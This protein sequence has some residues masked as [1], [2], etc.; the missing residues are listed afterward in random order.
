MVGVSESTISRWIDKH[1]IGHKVSGRYRV[2][3]TALLALI[4]ND[5]EALTAYKAGD[6]LHPSLKAYEVGAV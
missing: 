5:Q 3:T 4:D 6:M 2:N 1:G